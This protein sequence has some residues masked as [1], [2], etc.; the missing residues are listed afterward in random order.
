MRGKRSFKVSKKK[1]KFAKR[2]SHFFPQAVLVASL[3]PP[4]EKQMGITL[5][6]FQFFFETLNGRLPLKLRSNRPQTLPKC[7]S[8]DSRHF[9]FRHPKKKFSR[10][11][12][13][14]K[15]HFSSLFSFSFGGTTAKRTSK[16]DSSQFFALDTLILSSVR[17]KIDETSLKNVENTRRRRRRRQ[18]VFPCFFP[19]AV[20][21]LGWQSTEAKRSCDRLY[22]CC[23]Q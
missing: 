12:W 16:S 7:V 11:C 20:L 3:V 2:Y 14:S 23:R 1:L 9:I 5:R 19:Q 13:V 6:E 17:P 15:N 21:W 8:G 4:G 18:M 10:I 22:P